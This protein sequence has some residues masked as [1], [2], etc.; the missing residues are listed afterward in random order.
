MRNRSLVISVAASICLTCTVVSSAGAAG[1][2]SS[3]AAA[4]RL[5]ANE[6]IKEAVESPP[7]EKGKETVKSPPDEKGK[8]TVKSPPEVKG[9]EAGKAVL[10][11]TT[12]KSAGNYLGDRVVFVRNVL[13]SSGVRVED[14]VNTYKDV[15]IP[16]GF[17]LRGAGRTADSILFTAIH[18]GS[19][20][21]P[22]K[23]RI[24]VCR[25]ESK[26]ECERKCNQKSNQKSKQKCE[27]EC[28]QEC[29][30]DIKEGATIT[31]PLSVLADNVPDRYGLS[32]GALVVP[33]KFQL[34]HDHQFSGSA[35]VGPY[36]GYRI[37][38]TSLY[39]WALTVVGFAGASNISITE[40]KTSSTGETS[41]ST[42]QLAGFSYGLGLLGDVKS[43]FQLGV[44]LGFD[45]VG[46]G[47][48]TFKYN[49][50][51]WLAFELGYSFSQ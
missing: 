19:S 16:A 5:L 21:N 44:V 36:V 17:A 12:A 28:E 10:G 26:Q 9:S 51:P 18:A 45:S 14:G 42:K 8:E 25:Q 23:E 47:H 6:K 46:G 32:Y 2:A 34:T 41:N 49:Y 39:G 29:E 37:D 1:D 35:T 13:P 15:C 38:K 48:K 43:S 30:K 4:V 27:Q 50:M 7:D 22:D 33:F 3:A 20:C 11:D 31:V 24:K 40:T